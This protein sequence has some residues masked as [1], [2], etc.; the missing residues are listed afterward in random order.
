[1]ITTV[2]DCAS[3]FNAIRA[4]KSEHRVLCTGIAALDEYFKLAKRYMMVITG[5][6]SSGKSEV[7]DA[8]LLN[9]SIQH[10]WKN[11]LFSPENYPVEEHIVKHA[12]R[13]IGKPV[14]EFHDEDAARA[15]DF[16]GRHFSWI[17]MEFPQLDEVLATAKR[18]KEEKG[19]DSLTI[20]PW[21][22]LA[23]NRGQLRED[24]YLMDVLTRL[25]VFARRED[26]F[27]C[28]I[29]HPKTPMPDKDGKYPDPNL[30]SISG[31]AMWR[32]KV[33]YGLVVHRPDLAKHEAEVRIGKV[34]QIWMGRVGCATIKYQPYNGRFKGA[35][36]KEFLLPDEIPAPF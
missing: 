20:D 14:R 34:K 2:A 18:V 22:G 13:Y 12:A 5:Y 21:N 27:L 28:V 3:P 6:P 8:I 7:W 36:D 30:Y 23:H 35:F 9:M 4:G 32:N 24:E 31:G 17:N 15:L 25:S 26:I 19:L 33:D 10:G 16:L 11:L 29:A 1:M